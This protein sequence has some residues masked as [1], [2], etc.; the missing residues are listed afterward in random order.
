MLAKIASPSNR[1]LFRSSNNS[2]TTIT[3]SYVRPLFSRPSLRGNKRFERVV[4]NPCGTFLPRR[5]LGS[6]AAAVATKN[7]PATSQ[8]VEIKKKRRNDIEA[9]P[10]LQLERITKKVNGDRIIFSDFSATFLKGA[11]IGI[12]GVNG[13]GKSS[14]FRIIA[15]TDTD[16]DG[17]VHNLGGIKIGYLAQEPQLDPEKDV[18]G[19]VLLGVEDK[20]EILEEYE[21]LCEDLEDNDEPDRQDLKRK[22]HLERIIKEE[23]LLDLQRR[24]ER[25]MNALRCPPGD[26]DV[27]T[28]SGG[29]RRRVALCRLLISQ[30]DLL[31]LDEPTNHLDTESVAWL[32]RYLS[33]YS[34]TVLA[35][36][37]D[38]YF[39]DNVASW[40]LEIDRGRIIP[41]KGNY[42]EWLD[43]RERRLEHE[44]IIE[45][46]RNK[47]VKKELE[48]LRSTPRARQA[49][50]KARVAKFDELCSQARIIPPEPGT[51]LIPPAPRLGKRVI[52]VENLS[53]E[54]NGRVLFSNLSFSIEPGAIVGIIGPNGSGKTTLLRIIS[55]EIKASSGSVYV[56]E[57]VRLGAVSQSRNGLDPHKTV[58]QEIAS[59]TDSV[60]M[61]SQQIPIRNYIAAF[62]FNGSKQ[63][64]L[65][66]SLSG[67]ERNRLHLAKMIKSGINL[68]MLDE[69]TNDLDVEVLR[70]LESAVA[71][72]DG[73][74][75]IVSH[76]RYFLDRI[77]T[78]ILAFEDDGPIFFNGCYSEYIE[79]KNKRLGIENDQPKIKYTRMGEI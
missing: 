69:P 26:A 60:Q 38:R 14:L 31:L 25:A 43:F 3:T 45:E 73:S 58:Y 42:S 56:G 47:L 65:V 68:L 72:F 79:S 10:I 23:K 36:T 52:E 22:E 59:G 8:E 49:K 4:P 62:Q 7:A 30:P 37:H 51:I 46:K 76:D 63:Q 55:Q 71:K 5:A 57:T 78:H 29:E 11:K 44:S 75:L 66:G 50:N 21:E 13:S 77:C 15:G 9:K 33:E 39:L 24:V 2:T 32:E 16:F 12:I 35:I 17:E 20:M 41:F 34:G 1:L 54:F 19:N 40:V 74:A 53:A 67:G 70:N 48:W 61:G 28:L 27:T 6:P 18:M 64:Q